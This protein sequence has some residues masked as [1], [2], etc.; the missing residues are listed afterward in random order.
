MFNDFADLSDNI[1]KIIPINRSSMLFDHVLA[2]II[3]DTYPYPIQY[4]TELDYYLIQYDKSKLYDPYKDISLELNKVKELCNRIE[5]INMNNV[6]DKKCLYRCDNNKTHDYK[7]CP[8]SSN[9]FIASCIFIVNGKLCD[10]TL[11][12]HKTRKYC[13]EHL[14]IGPLCNLK[15]CDNI[16]VKDTDYCYMHDENSKK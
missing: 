3:D 6:A 16:R 15:Y 8:F 7:Y 13:D 4:F 10:N 12:N 11:N 5:N 2:Y 14:K 9:N 1:T